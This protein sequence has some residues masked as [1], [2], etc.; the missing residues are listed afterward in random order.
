MLDP[1]TST[2]PKTKKKKLELDPYTSTKAKTP[3][4]HVSIEQQNLQNPPKKPKHF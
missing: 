3:G 2:K 4:T 1:Q